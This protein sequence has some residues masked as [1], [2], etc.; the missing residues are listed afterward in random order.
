[1]RIVEHNSGNVSY[2]PDWYVP[3]GSA[4]AW[5]YRKF[6]ESLHND[7]NVAVNDSSALLVSHGIKQGK[8]EIPT[9]PT[10]NYVSWSCMIIVL[11]CIPY[12]LL[13]FYL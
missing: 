11:S 8:E 4:Y 13:F 2:F 1:M 5:N 6:N 9:T 12:W 7:M 10:T 3:I